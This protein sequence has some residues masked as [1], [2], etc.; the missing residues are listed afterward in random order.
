MNITLSGAVC[1]LLFAALVFRCKFRLYALVTM[2]LCMILLRHFQFFSF[3]E[4]LDLMLD[5]DILLLISLCVFLMG[6]AFG[7]RLRAGRI[8]RFYSGLSRCVLTDDRIFVSPR[9][10]ATYFWVTVFYCAFDLWL[11]TLLYG[12]L[13]SA[14]IRFYAKPTADDFPT[15]LHTIQGF[16][17]KALVVFVFV[18]R[19]YLNKL[20]HRSALFGLTVLLLVLIAVPKGSRGAAVAPFMMLVMADFF[21]FTF[22]KG[23]SIR[24]KVREY[25]AIGCI[26]VFLILTLTVIRNIDFDEIEDVYSA[27]SEL[28]MGDASDSYSQGEGEML[29]EDVQRCYTEFGNRVDFLSPFYTLETLVLA[30]IPRVLMPQKKVS[31][32]NVFNEVKMGGTN[33][34]HP[35]NLVY[36]G[37][38]GWAAGLAGEGWANGGLFGVV[39]YALLFGIYSGFCAKMYYHLL[40]CATPLALLF[41]LLFFQMSFSFIRGDLLAGYVQGLYPLLILT[42]LFWTIKHFKKYRIRFK[43]SPTT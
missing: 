38:V 20:H 7:K 19:F 5:V 16:L 35:E 31:F 23:M 8:E 25:V 1:I 43:L 24:G 15:I 18:F 26:S 13:E 17:F 12:S 2:P 29:L 27:V 30:P 28:N 36:H 22:Q 32:G 10:V 11:N 42:F 4:R 34:N 21:S 14:L 33:L 41:S 9:A 3:Y 37:A 40:T 39:F 6:Y